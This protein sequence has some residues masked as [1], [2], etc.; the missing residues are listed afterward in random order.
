MRRRRT[1]GPAKRDGDEREEDRAV[2]EISTAGGLGVCVTDRCAAAGSR[3]DG[4]GRGR[5]TTTRLPAWAGTC[6]VFHFWLLHIKEARQS[7]TPPRCPR[8]LLL[9]LG[10][11]LHCRKTKPLGGQG[12][13]KKKEKKDPPRKGRALVRALDALCSGVQISFPSHMYSGQY[14]RGTSLEYGPYV[15]SRRRT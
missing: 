6:Y 13:R 10:L 1:A 11:A 7:S 2:S 9:P 4:R 3:P 14:S 5:G 15:P 12:R 8:F